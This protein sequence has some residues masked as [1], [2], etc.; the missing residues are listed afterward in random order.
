MYLKE[1][2]NEISISAVAEHDG[3]YC[4]GVRLVKPRSVQEVINPELLFKSLYDEKIFSFSFIQ[5]CNRKVYSYNIYYCQ[6]DPA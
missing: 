5:F 6:E 1:G 2:A 3:I 4:M